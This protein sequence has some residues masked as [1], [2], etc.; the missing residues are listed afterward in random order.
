MQDTHL[1][2][3][4]TTH[5]QHTS[6]YPPFLTT[7]SSLLSPR[8]VSHLAVVRHRRQGLQGQ[9][10]EDAGAGCGRGGVRLLG[11]VQRA[12]GS[13]GHWLVGGLIHIIGLTIDW[14]VD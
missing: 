2:R 3:L 8:V 9:G 13:V 10:P 1:L 7:L 11:A 14:L 12:G 5:S 4:L 6:T